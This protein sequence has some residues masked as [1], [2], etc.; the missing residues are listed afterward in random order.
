MITR[1]RSFLDVYLEG[2]SEGWVAV[3]FSSSANM[4]SMA[5]WKVFYAEDKFKFSFEQITLGCPMSF[6]QVWTILGFVFQATY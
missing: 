5:G 6:W 2:D 1:V 3:G 4:V